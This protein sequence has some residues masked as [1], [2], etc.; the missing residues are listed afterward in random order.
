MVF[1]C[2][3]GMHC[4]NGMYGVVNPAGQGTLEAY[5]ALITE[6]KVAV[7]PASVGGGEFVTAGTESGESEESEESDPTGK[8]TGFSL[9]SSLASIAGALGVALLMV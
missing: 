8:N 5:G 4:S 9:K 7:A 6:P 3:Q 1:Y 2:T